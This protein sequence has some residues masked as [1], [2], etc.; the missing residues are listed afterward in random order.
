MDCPFCQD[1]FNHKENRMIFSGKEVFVIT[2]N[3]RLIFG[4][5]LVIP[6]RHIERPSEMTASER[7]EIFETIL[8]FQDMILEKLGGGCDIRENYRPF[9]KQNDLKVDHIHF[10]L[11]PRQNDDEIYTVYENLQRN[12]FKKMTDEEVAESVKIFDFDENF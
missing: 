7:Q 1:N 3:P 6:K 8:K 5:L 9:Q 10:H 12:V 4:H 11:I 2:S